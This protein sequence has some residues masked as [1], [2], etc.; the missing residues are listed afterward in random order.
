MYNEK[1]IFD[2][3]FNTRNWDVTD[4]CP[5]ISRS[6]G[7]HEL[8]I[9]LYQNEDCDDFIEIE[10]VSYEQVEGFWGTTTYETKSEYSKKYCLGDKFHSELKELYLKYHQVT[11]SA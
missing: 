8:Y 3:V 10:V 4:G 6:V 5:C 1:Q 11:M 9:C 2:I 7:E